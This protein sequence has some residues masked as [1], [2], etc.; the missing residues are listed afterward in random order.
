MKKQR[1]S[2]PLLFWMKR[3]P[4]ETYERIAKG[5][6]PATR[7][8]TESLRLITHAYRPVSW[9]M[10]FAISEYTQKRDPL[11]W[12]TAMS[13]RYQKRSTARAKKRKAA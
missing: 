2:T 4:L 5:I 7:P 12:V 13:L 11:D 8:V 9:E 3:H 10:C 1:E 6:N